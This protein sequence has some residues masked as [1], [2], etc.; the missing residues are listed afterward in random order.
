MEGI[1]RYPYK[2]LFHL[3]YQGPELYGSVYGVILRCADEICEE[4]YIMVII[5]T[6]EI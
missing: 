3:I 4:Q 5:C 1:V 6:V 2:T